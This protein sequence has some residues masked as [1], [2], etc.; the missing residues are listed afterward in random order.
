MKAETSPEFYDKDTNGGGSV[1]STPRD[2][3]NANELLVILAEA[4]A[5]R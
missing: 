3:V 5:R 2:I 1:D 4:K